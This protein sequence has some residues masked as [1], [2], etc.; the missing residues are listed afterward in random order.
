MPTLSEKLDYRKEFVL[1]VEEYQK[2]SEEELWKRL[3]DGALPTSSNGDIHLI[4][5]WVAYHEG[6]NKALTYAV[7]PSRGHSYALT[8]TAGNRRY[9]VVTNPRDHRDGVKVISIG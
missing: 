9:V 6:V 4:G 2:P 1:G 5:A 8:D 7:W 3:Y